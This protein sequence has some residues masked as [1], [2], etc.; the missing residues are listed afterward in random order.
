[1]NKFRKITNQE[2][3]TELKQRMPNFAQIDL[4]ELIKSLGQHRQQ[5]ETLYQ[6]ISPEFSQWYQKSIQ[7]MKEIKK[8]ENWKV[9]FPTNFKN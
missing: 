2:L 8:R 7:E 6:V 5:L 1:M 3:L 4:I 9:N